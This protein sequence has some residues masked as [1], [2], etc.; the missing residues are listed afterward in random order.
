[1]EVFDLRASKE[2]SPDRHVYKTLAETLHCAISVVGWEPGQ[3]SPIH[4][5][6]GADEIYHVL[7]GEGL[8]DDGRKERRLGPG[9]TVVFPAGEVHRVRS[10]TRMVLYRVQA[11]ADR[12]PE[13]VDAWPGRSA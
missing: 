3:T 6:P 2:F 5:H 10:V 13:F 7:E 1:M 11:G 12:H 9:D 8:F 4:S